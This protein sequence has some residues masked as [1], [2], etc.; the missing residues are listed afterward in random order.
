MRPP[1][2]WST[3]CRQHLQQQHRKQRI[4]PSIKIM[5]RIDT[6]GTNS[7]TTWWIA[8]VQNQGVSFDVLGLSCYTAYAD[9][10]PPANWQSNFSS[11]VTQ[12]PNLSFAMAEYDEGAPDISGNLNVWRQA[13]DIVFNLPNKKGL[14]TFFFEPTFTASWD[15]PL[16]DF[17]SGN[18]V[19]PLADPLAVRS[20]AR[21]ASIYRSLR[22]ASDRCRFHS[23]TARTRAF[24]SRKRSRACTSQSRT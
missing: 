20:A 15:Q 23:R 19:T 5:M 2:Q 1:P 4:D 17:T 24:I 16:F 8:G 13:N 6:G 10:G 3:D 14:G 22:R 7:T 12:Y 9:Q 18:N 11:L 21:G